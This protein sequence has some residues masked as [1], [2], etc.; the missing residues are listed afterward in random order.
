MTRVRPLIDG[1][2]AAHA[3]FAPRLLH[4]RDERLCVA[5]LDAASRLVG[6][7]LRYSAWE[8]DVELPL[9]AIIADAVKLGSHAILLAHDPPSGDPTPSEADLTATRTLVR[10]ARPLAVRVR[11]HLLFGG[12]DFV[13]LRERGL[14]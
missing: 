2:D 11:D 14:L 1:I 12:G 6:F 10:I 4:A 9:R 7:R 13:S 8:S 3:L 5:Y